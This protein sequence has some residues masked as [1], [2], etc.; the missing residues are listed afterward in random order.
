MWT[1]DTWD[2]FSTKIVP[3]SW[4]ISSSPTTN[5][6]PKTNL[7]SECPRSEQSVTPYN[8]M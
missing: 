6:F 2:T 8:S 7:L 4:G 3:S 5:F 1:I